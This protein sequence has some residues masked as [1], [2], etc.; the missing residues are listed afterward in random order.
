MALQEIFNAGQTT[1]PPASA[2]TTAI[3]LQEAEI[4]RDEYNLAISFKDNYGRTYSFERYIRVKD[5]SNWQMT[6]DEWRT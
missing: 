4:H 3:V 2:E 5:H 1:V 6:Q